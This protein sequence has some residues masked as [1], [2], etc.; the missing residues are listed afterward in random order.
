MLEFQ[1]WGNKEGLNCF[2]YSKNSTLKNILPSIRIMGWD[3]ALRITIEDSAV[4]FY[5]IIKI[6]DC[7]I[8]NRFFTTK[9]SYGRNM[10]MVCTSVLM[11]ENYQIT[12]KP[13][14][15][16]L[17]ELSSLYIKNYFDENTEKIKPGAEDWS[18]FEAMVQNTPTVPARKKK[19]CPLTEQ[20]GKYGYIKY[21]NDQDIRDYLDNP[22]RAEYAGFKEIYFIPSYVQGINVASNLTD[23]TNVVPPKE[24]TYQVVFLPK[25]SGTNGPIPELNASNTIVKINNES[26]TFPNTL[27]VCKD[28]VLNIVVQKLDEYESAPVLVTVNDATI[29]QEKVYVNIPLT[30]KLKTVWLCCTNINNK[31][32]SNLQIF[33][34]SQNGS[35]YNVKT[36]QDGR[37][38]LKVKLGEELSYEIK[39]NNYKEQTGKISYSDNFEKKILLEP[40]VVH[41]SNHD[42]KHRTGNHQPQKGNSSV[43]DENLIK[44]PP[45]RENKVLI[46][47]AM[48]LIITALAIGLYLFIY[49]D[50]EPVMTTQ[51]PSQGPGLNLDS[52]NSI[53]KDDSSE[54]AKLVLPKHSSR[55]DFLKMTYSDTSN[56]Q[57]FQSIKGY[58]SLLALFIINRDSIESIIS[59]H[60]KTTSGSGSNNI[61]PQNPDAFDT[62]KIISVTALTLMFGDKAGTRLKEIEN[63]LKNYQGSDKS[64]LESNCKALKNINECFTKFKSSSK[65]QKEVEDAISCIEQNKNKLSSEQKAILKNKIKEKIK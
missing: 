46:T 40:R 13:T 58:D 32:V 27:E 60:K 1:F 24:K 26:V 11:K 61:Q 43:N 30:I 49:K 55:I 16:F 36:D 5:S 8:Y 17:F 4:S 33:I 15:D 28:D 22:W 44:D 65:F 2:Y 51:T 7:L 35:V 54:I 34:K 29:T 56:S 31:E 41:P 38:S 10:G 19:P 21:Q 48:V 47:I 23:L 25:V 53:L 57:L 50:Q 59:R 39:D 6:A 63:G 37:V 9:D 14:F 12:D 20:S 18:V 45:I 52:L 3:P 42:T 64:S 62:N